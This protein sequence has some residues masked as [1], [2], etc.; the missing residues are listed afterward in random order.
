MKLLYCVA[1]LTAMI[2]LGRAGVLLDTEILLIQAYQ[3]VGSPVTR[4]MA[5]CRY[6]PTCSNFALTTL[7]EDGFWQGNLKTGVR[8][9]RCSPLGLLIPGEGSAP[10]K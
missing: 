1:V 6:E 10:G 9:V 3:K 8:L 7:R 4:Y 2:V 5:T